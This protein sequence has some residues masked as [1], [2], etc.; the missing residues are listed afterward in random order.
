MSPASKPLTAAEAY[1]AA[2]HDMDEARRSAGIMGSDAKFSSCLI[3]LYEGRIARGELP[4][5]SQERTS[6]PHGSDPSA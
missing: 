6:E 3:E 4:P 2:I 5:L 1:R